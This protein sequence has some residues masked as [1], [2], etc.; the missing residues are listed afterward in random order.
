[1]IY[2]VDSLKEMLDKSNLWYIRHYE[3]YFDKVYMVYLRG[4]PHEWVTVGN[5]TL[6]SVSSGNGKLDFLLAPYRLYRLA[7]KIRPTNYVTPDQ[8]YSWWISSLLQLLLRAKIFLLPQFL[9]DQIYSTSHKSVS[10]LFP[11]WLEKFF[12]SLSYSSVYKVLTGTCFG[13]LPNILMAHRAA[14]KKMI[15]TDVLVEAVPPPRFFEKLETLNG[16]PVRSYKRGE[17]FNL[18]YV[19]RLQRQKLVD[20]LVKMMASIKKLNHNGVPIKLII[21]GDGPERANVEQLIDKL[22]VRSSIEFA[23]AVSNEKIPDYMQRSDVYISTIGGMA[24]RE[25]GLYGLPIVTYDIDWVQ[26][27]LKHEE[28][29]LTVPAGDYEEM[30]RQVIRLSQDDELRARLSKNMKEFAWKRWSPKY[31]RESLRKVFE[32]N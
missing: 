6:A 4:T 30:A 10:M 9:P 22:D 29:A 2:S 21:V 25:A 18:I 32:E 28:N 7:K 24:F 19:G 16:S 13:N 26:G 14:R 15:I 8:I 12:I 23:G 17:Q 11:I 31:L 5:T 20:L 3:A 1:M 27:Y